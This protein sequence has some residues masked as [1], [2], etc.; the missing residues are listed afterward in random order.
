MG[1]L[2]CGRESGRWNCL[3]LRLEDVNR[4]HIEQNCSCFN[5]LP[6]NVL[7]AGKLPSVTVM[8]KCL[9]SWV[10]LAGDSQGGSSTY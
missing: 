2:F 3:M 10:L 5:S 4:V 7:N 1:A 9:W 6:D 8:L